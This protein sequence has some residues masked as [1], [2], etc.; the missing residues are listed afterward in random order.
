MGR[1]ESMGLPLFVVLSTQ[2][3][4]SSVRALYRFDVDQYR[5]TLPRLSRGRR[6]SCRQS[7]AAIHLKVRS[8]HGPHVA[9]HATKHA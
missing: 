9:S 3:I 7:A 2:S 1:E 5:R 6:L 8:A 4:L